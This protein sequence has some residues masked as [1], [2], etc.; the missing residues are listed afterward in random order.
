MVFATIFLVLTVVPMLPL[1]LL[2]VF[3]VDKDDIVGGFIFV[4]IDLQI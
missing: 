2:F 1:K 3:V 4:D